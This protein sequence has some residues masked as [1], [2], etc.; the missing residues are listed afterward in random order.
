MKE[1][2]NVNFN[3]PMPSGQTTG[4]KGIVIEGLDQFIGNRGMSIRQ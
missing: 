4:K 1:T 2:N 3:Q